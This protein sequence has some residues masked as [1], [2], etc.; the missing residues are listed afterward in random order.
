MSHFHD[1]ARTAGRRARARALWA[2]AGLAAGAAMSAQSA[3][4]QSGGNALGSGTALQKRLGQ[5]GGGAS[6]QVAPGAARPTIANQARLNNAIVTGEVGGG[7]QFRG[8]VGYSGAL[9]FRGR[10]GSD[11][12]FRFQRDSFASGL[13]ARGVSGIDGLQQQM[14]LSTNA[15]PSALANSTVLQRESAG[16]SGASLAP[17]RA[18]D[19]AIGI[20]PA[21]LQSGSLRSLSRF[22]TNDASDPWTFAP[23]GGAQGDGSQGIGASSLRGVYALP[24]APVPGAL[25]SGRGPI[26]GAR[27]TT[28][29]TTPARP[30]AIESGRLSSAAEPAPEGGKVESE[31]TY[32]RLVKQL[33]EGRVGNARQAPPTPESKAEAKEADA[34]EAGAPAGWVRPPEEPAKMGEPGAPEPAPALPRPPGVE[35]A[36]GEAPT[37]TDQNRD[38]PETFKQRLDRLRE[39]LM[40]AGAETDRDD[41]S[42][43]QDDENADDEARGAKPDKESVKK[44]TA[45]L[46]GGV[47]PRVAT[48]IDPT[49]D[50]TALQRNMLAGQEALAKNKWFDAEESFTKAMLAR[51]DDPMPA[52]A[53]MHA[54]LGAGMFLSAAINARTVFRA[55]P[56]LAAAEYDSALLPRAERLKAVLESLREAA[57]RDDAHGRDAG[58]LLAYLGRQTGSAEDVETGLAAVERI[59]ARLGVTPDPLIG[60]LRALWQAGG[61]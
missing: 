4:A 56:E 47:R 10:T 20:N 54:Q 7:R 18:G 34:K 55:H 46:L 6:A 22:T 16:V 49:T 35:A 37:A 58:L 2:I 9:D 44:E 11:D 57:T 36:P 3:S 13:A 15:L 5:S 14:G 1:V 59:E 43:D 28:P 25:A 32:Q 12:L 8:S 26:A 45:D 21:T 42:G 60:A 48:F 38:E 19:S 51:P 39:T 50:P 31:S 30:G 53:R 41:G 61:R 33:E 17:T 23:R 40:R 27:P 24:P 52:I 29:A